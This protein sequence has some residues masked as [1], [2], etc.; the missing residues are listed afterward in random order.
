MPRGIFGAVLQGG[1][2]LTKNQSDSE[3]KAELL[4]EGG[5]ASL[6]GRGGSQSVREKWGDCKPIRGNKEP[7][8]VEI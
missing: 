2:L 1:R 8:E 4:T 6:W 7:Q 5:G 3:T